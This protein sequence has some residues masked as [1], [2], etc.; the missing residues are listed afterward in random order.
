MIEP[1]GRVR[2]LERG[3]PHA[4]VDLAALLLVASVSKPP[5]AAQVRRR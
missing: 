5:S 2:P 1:R 3:R 4:G